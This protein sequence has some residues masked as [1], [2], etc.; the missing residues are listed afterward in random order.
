[1]GGEWKGRGKK[2]EKREESDRKN[3]KDTRSK[4]GGR[5]SWR[6]MIIRLVKELRQN[7]VG[8]IVLKGEITKR[9]AGEI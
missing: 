8:G 9:E 3:N 7:G 4:K 6:R 1:M 5:A 2:A